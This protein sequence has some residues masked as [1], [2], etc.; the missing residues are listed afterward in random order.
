MSD[1]PYL[2]SP[3]DIGGV[4]SRNRIM[5][6]GH[7]KQFSHEGVDSQRDLSYFVD[8]AKGGM[9]LMITGNRFIHPTSSAGAAR[10]SWAFLR[11]AIPVDRRITTEVHNHGAVIIAQ[12][13]H[14]GVN[15][16]SDNVD[17][18]RVLWGPSA[19]ESPAYAETPKEMEVEDIAEVVDWWG[20]GAEYS[21]EGGFDGVEVHLA[22]AYLLHQFISPLYNHRKDQYGGSLE[23]RMRFAM[24]VIAEVRRRVGDD[25]VVGVR[26]TL[27][28]YV[29]GGLTIEDAVATARMLE[30]AGMIDF[31]N[32]T[33]GGYHDGLFHAIAT[34][35]LSAGWLVEMTAQVRAAVTGIPVF[36]VGGLS[37]PGEAEAILR[38]GKADMVAMTRAQIAE[39]EWANKVREGR[40]DELQH[41]IR[42][43]Q[44]CINRSFKGLAISCTVNPAAGREAKLGLGTL[45]EAES[46]GRWLVIGGGP[47]GMRAA[48]TLSRRG[49]A[50]SLVERQSD[51]GGQLNLAKVLPGRES[52]ARVTED[53]S[54]QLEKLGVEVKLGFEAT[55]NW[56]VEYEADGV[57]VATGARPTKTG[58]ASIAPMVRELPGV[59]RSNVFTPW[60]VIERTVP[61]HGRAVVLDDDGTRYVAG[62]VEILLDQGI[63][64]ELI[65]RHNALFPGTEPTLDLG[66][67][68]SRLFSKGLT[69]HLNSWARSVENRSV[70][71][72]NLYT[73]ATK[74]VEDVDFVVLGTKPR[75]D[76][77]LYRE[78]KGQVQGLHR[79]GDCLA[80]RQLDNA[81]YDAELAGREL[82]SA[83]DRYIVE[84][85]LE[86]W[87]HASSEAE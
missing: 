19:V 4:T 28:D 9:G 39:P 30:K 8:R 18:L 83:E 75:A 16:S 7:S 24:E 46:P 67:I 34:A 49:H 54:R 63:D 43:N 68:Y 69:Y 58:F 53:L 70:V 48:V 3:L 74:T 78:L 5:Q 40:E 62:I 79:I 72:Y 26:I 66:E 51:L 55:P 17:D 6:T 20:L 25:F 14:F 32:V 45:V 22:H 36:V 35:D 11:E 84:G 13:N 59:D 10:F 23:N 12:L 47:A 56:A 77:W 57:L 38:D 21:R 60:D 42:A 41:C 2:F 65:S 80:P 15:G 86:R 81:I 71:T 73:S 87:P 50:V 27:S 31:I 82:W 29:E 33:A 61:Q 37:E 76:D 44:G 52:F 1:Y 64:V 85:E